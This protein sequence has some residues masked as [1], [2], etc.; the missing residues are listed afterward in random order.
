MSFVLDASATLAWHFEDEATEDV[1]A[2]ARRAFEEGI[3]VPQHWLLEVVSALLRGERRLRASA[4]RTNE[5][6]IGLGN[7][8]VE[9]DEFDEGRVVTVMLPL[10]REKRLSLY[11][12]AYLELAHRRRLP[13]ATLDGS[14]ARAARDM[15]VEL[16]LGERM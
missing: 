10:A 12:A 11:D 2:I 7:L 3:K 14:L 5:F 4:D 15:G 1:R 6:I 13:L 9:V 16:L 8:N